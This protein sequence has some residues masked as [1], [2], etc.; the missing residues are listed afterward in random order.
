[1][2]MNVSACILFL[3]IV[4]SSVGYGGSSGPVVQQG[5]GA[6]YAPVGS[7]VA[8]A[9]VLGNGTLDTARSKNVVAMAGGNGL[10]C[11][12]LTFLPKNAVAT[13]DN[14]PTSPEQGL[15]FVKVALRPTATFTCAKIPVPDA[16][17][18]TAKQTTV[19]GGAS[20]GGW[21]FYVFWTE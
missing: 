16:T 18:M 8:Y 17:V 12:D 6:T 15:G 10:Y 9:H 2:K 14:D 1:M 7:R 20:D 13:L 19:G 11:F 21:P 5:L 4:A 3:L